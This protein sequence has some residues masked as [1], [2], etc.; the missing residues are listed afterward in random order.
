MRI[1]LYWLS[2]WLPCRIISEVGVPYLERYYVCT[3]FGSRCYLHRFVGSDPGRAHH[4]H[5]WPWA[6]SVV[7]SGWYW[8]GRLT[9]TRAVRWFN[10]IRGDVF[11]RVGLPAEHGVTSV[12]TIFVHRAVD[13]K[14]WGFLHSG[15]DGASRY[16]PASFP[17]ESDQNAWWKTAPRG[18]DESRRMPREGLDDSQMR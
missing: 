5:P 13:A 16:A 12:W 17:K 15:N 11:H 8:E 7:L 2:G 14:P 18:R 1:F 9:G 6:F 4:D 10:W 3:V